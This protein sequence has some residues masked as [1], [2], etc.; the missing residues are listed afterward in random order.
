MIKKLLAVAAALIM[1]AGMVS[2]GLTGGSDDDSKADT[3]AAA[4]KDKDEDKDE[5]KS[6]AD[7][8]E[9]DTKDKDDKSAESK[10]EE[11]KAEDSKAEE[12]KSDDSSKAESKPS[13][14]SS[15][16]GSYVPAADPKSDSIKIDDEDEIKLI[17]GNIIYMED[18]IDE[19]EDKPTDDEIVAAISAVIKQ[20]KAAEALEASAFFDTIKLDLL[21]KPFMEMCKLNFSFGSQEEFNDY[22]DK[23]KMNTRYEMLDDVSDLLQEIGDSDLVDQID[24][25]TVD[26]D[27]DKITELVPKLFESIDPKANDFGENV[28]YDTIFWPDEP[29]DAMEALDENSVYGFMLE[30]C[31]RNGSDFYMKAYVSILT[32]NKEY[33]IDE[34][35]VWMIDGE[36]GVWAGDVWT[37]ERDDETAG[38]NGPQVWDTL[39]KLSEAPVEDGITIQDSKAEQ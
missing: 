23:N 32:E 16:S 18:T 15:T 19:L 31:G 2:C 30:E 9:K 28:E 21:Q 17:N 6:E 33:D 14:T 25:A 37:S 3:T 34:I 20:Y 12:S 38:L 1:C 27:D 13:T 39:K 5:E 8:A 36:C 4:S 29:I 24:D 10:A 26:E 11:S 22:L 35:W 7:N